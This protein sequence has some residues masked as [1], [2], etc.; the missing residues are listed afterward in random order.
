MNIKVAIALLFTL[1]LAACGSPIDEN[2][3]REIHS[4][5][6]VDQDGEQV[7]LP[8]DLEGEYW[9]ADF[10]FTSCE[11]VCPPMTGNMARLQQML[12]E[13]DLD[14]PL[15]S[16]SVDPEHDTPAQLKQFADPYKPD[17][18]QWRFLTGYSFHEVKELS[19]KSFQSP[20]K[21]LADSNQFAH[22]TSFF[23]VTP[24]GEVI[25]R[26]S[27][28]KANEMEKIVSDVKRLTQ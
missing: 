7:E 4:F 2:M 19:I 13:E 22:G 14:I 6:A 11:T 12:K 24:D 1:F 21:K 10:I 23:L 3:A 26:Y 17:Y 25:K 5:S 15:R 9:V 18:S 28:T 27:G 20:L 8:Q 16:F